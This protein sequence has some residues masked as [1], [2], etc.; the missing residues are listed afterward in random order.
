MISPRTVIRNRRIAPL[1]DPRVMPRLSWSK[2]RRVDRRQGLWLAVWAPWWVGNEMPPPSPPGTD[3]SEMLQ[4]PEGTAGAWVLDTLDDLRFR[5]GLSWSVAL[6]LRGAWLGSMVGIGWVLLAMLTG[7]GTP[8]F[9]QLTIAVVAGVVLGLVLRLFHRP[10]YRSVA[11]MLERSFGLQSRLSTAVLGLRHARQGESGLHHLQLADAANVLERARERLTPNHWVP[12]REIFIF[13]TVALTLLLLLVAQ[14]PEGEI[15]AMSSAAVPRFVPV[16][17]RLASMDQQE[18]PPQI[19]NASTLEEAAEVSRASNQ[20]RQDLES[21]GNALEGNSVTSPAASAIESGNYPEAN[22][23][24]NEASESVSQLPEDQREALADD[25]D[26]AADQ[27]SEDNPELAESARNASDDVRAGEDTGALDELGEQIET[28]GESVQSQQSGAGE[29]PDTQSDQQSGT[30]SGAPGG[31]SASGEQQQPEQ[32]GSGAT[33]APAAQQGDPG[34]GMEA[35]GG[36]GSSEE[37]DQQGQGGTGE[38]GENRS[39]A[40][41]EG[42][43]GQ[44]SQPGEASRDQASGASSSSASGNSEDASGEGSSESGGVASDSEEEDNQGQGSGAGG[45]QSETDDQGEPTDSEGGGGGDLN[46]EEQ[47]PEA[48]EGRAGDPPPGGSEENEGSGEDVSTGGGSSSI[49]LPG[50]SDDRVMSG[51]DIGSSSVGSGGG[52]GAAS[53]DSSGSASGSAGPDP[54]DVPEEWR[55]IVEEYFED[56]GAP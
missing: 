24:L 38:Q 50:T 12:V 15:P 43:S 1:P 34:A 14:R 6:I 37:Q 44:S 17:E 13:F 22:R 21:I 54:N 9:A 40:S 27:V 28:T 4:P 7:I 48:G 32:G 29:L 33:D 31:S 45:G 25:L 55:R 52:V 41:G 56:G 49:T 46:N 3:E 30:Q 16:S 8:S 42:Q 20:A 23:Q 36:V 39:N 35:S 51:S 10:G 5:F 18:A 2:W 26:E 53:G 19:P 47:A 11:L